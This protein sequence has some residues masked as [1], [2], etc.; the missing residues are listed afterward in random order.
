MSEIIDLTQKLK[1]RAYEKKLK[2][3]HWKKDRL[4]EYGLVYRLMGAHSKELSRIEKIA[5]KTL[6]YFF[7]RFI[8]SERRKVS[9]IEKDLNQIGNIPE[10]NK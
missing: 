8:Y 1:E 7:K 2:R 5:I 6:S 4:N 9:I 10:E 3:L